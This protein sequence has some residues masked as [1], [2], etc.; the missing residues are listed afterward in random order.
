ML[1]FNAC[2]AEFDLEVCV[3]CLVDDSRF[4]DIGLIVIFVILR[5]GRVQFDVI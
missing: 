2:V 4:F 1:A 5:V 3:N